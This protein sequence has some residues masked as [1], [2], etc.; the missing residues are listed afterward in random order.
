MIKQVFMKRQKSRDRRN[1]GGLLYTSKHPK[2]RWIIVHLKEQTQAKSEKT[3]TEGRSLEG[4]TQQ[5]DCI[6]LLEKSVKTYHKYSIL[7][8]YKSVQLSNFCDI[9]WKSITI[10]FINYHIN[11]Q[12]LHYHH[13]KQTIS[14]KCTV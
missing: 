9:S 3:P 14:S 6:H 13:V 11:S 2:S 10:S 7:S 4:H 8:N 5:T 1:T 12:M